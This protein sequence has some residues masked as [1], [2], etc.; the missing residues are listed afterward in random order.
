MLELVTELFNQQVPSIT[1]AER[2]NMLGYRG[3]FGGKWSSKSVYMLMQQMGLVP[4]PTS[5][6]SLLENEGKLKARI[7]ELEDEVYG[8]S[9]LVNRVR[10]LEE[11]LQHMHEY[12]LSR[13][14]S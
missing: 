10:E 8:E 3:V 2:L 4:T 9:Y 6:K 5:Y 13:R 11:T 12:Y 1:I 7:A 14:N